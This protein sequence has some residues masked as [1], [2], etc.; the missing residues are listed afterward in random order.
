M[1]EFKKFSCFYRVK[2]G[3]LAAI[4]ELNMTVNDGELLVIVGQSGSGKTTL[5]KAILNICQD[6]SGELLVDGIPAQQIEKQDNLFAYVSQDYVL[7][8]R[9]VIYE[10]I[11]Y[12]L[13]TQ[14]TAQEEVDRRVREISR[15]LGLSYLLNRLP[16]QL[17]GGQHQRV[18][19][20]RAL[21][22]HPRYLLMD[23]PFSNVSPEQRAELR[24]LVRQIHAEFGTTI[25]FVTHELPEAFSLA[26][27][28]AVLNEGR[29]EE[30]GTPM[31]LRENPR[32]ELLTGFLKP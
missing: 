3:Y 32:S 23:E 4:D 29:L 24:E 11:A 16:R 21:I 26:D 10:N 9:M 5:L 17:S 22:K 27:R 19:I 25:L 12:P 28:I 2:Q 30:I 15:K 13:R 14:H 31:E 7:Y 6:V 20:A 8:P 18:A 1:I